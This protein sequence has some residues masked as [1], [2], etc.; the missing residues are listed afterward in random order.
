[1]NSTRQIWQEKIEP[2]KMAASSSKSMTEEIIDA[3]KDKT[4]DSCVSTLTKTHCVNL[5]KFKR[6]RLPEG[7]WITIKRFVN[8][9]N[10]PVP[11][12][13]FDLFGEFSSQSGSEVCDTMI[14]WSYDNF[15]MLDSA[16]K[17]AL[18]H[19]NTTLQAWLNNMADE[20]TPRDELT[21]YILA[22]MYRRHVYVFM[23]KF[24]WTTLLYTIPVSEK[25][26]MAQCD[27]VLVYIR[28]G[29]FGELEPI[30]GPAPTQKMGKESPPKLP[31]PPKA[32]THQTLDTQ[33]EQKQTKQDLNDRPQPAGITQSTL[34][35]DAQQADT[36]VTP[37]SANAPHTED[38]EETRQ[39]ASNT[40]GVT[41][42]L[43]VIP[44]SVDESLQVE[45]V[46]GRDEADSPTL[47]SIG[48][49]LSKTCTIPL[50]HCDFEQIK[51]TV[52]QQT[53][54]NKG[55]TGTS[56]QIQEE[57]T[58]TNTS[59]DTAGIGI[60][61]EGNNQPEICTSARKRTII[62]YKKFLEEYADKPPSPPKKK[63]E[64][65]LKRKPSKTRI[66]AEKYSRSRFF[67]KPTHLP[68]PVRRRKAKADSPVASGSME[69]QIKKANS[70]TNSETITIPATSHETQDV[71][72]ALL[73][74]GNPPEESLPGLEDNEVLMPI[75]RPQQTG[76]ELLPNVPPDANP[77]I[78][79]EPLGT[80]PK[81]GALLG[82]AVKTDQNENLTVTDD[83]PNDA[84]DNGDSQTDEK[85][86]KKKTFVTKEYGLKR[87]VKTKRKFKCG[88]CDAELDNVRDYNQHYLDNHPPIPCPILPPAF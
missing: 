54:Q 7:T 65:D 21:L 67:T 16:F 25:E 64:I 59:Q 43:G 3:I 62:D 19:R 60:P 8:K 57:N 26:L 20:H 10:R 58:C 2:L 18:R 32:S 70:T 52:E 75:K 42:T 77:P 55:E 23:Q 22:R 68:R 1:M 81:P 5:K 14:G 79:P 88:A 41:A 36:D 85:N 78:P 61:T 40:T 38:H 15:C 83:Q 76:P 80:V 6:E 12:A 30:R 34:V 56:D 31:T 13:M 50:I 72:D 73:L 84:D 71:I 46:A 29:V 44:E 51:K 45:T 66:A 53:M 17:V 48:V 63:K 47:P 87:R 39:Q 82:V 28:D 11:D 35:K 24:W 33:G 69:G 37:E 49:F 9:S 4:Y 74:L 86:R 27:V